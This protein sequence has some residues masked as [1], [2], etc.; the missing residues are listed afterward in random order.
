VL[1]DFV[2]DLAGQA[3]RRR[4]SGPRTLVVAEA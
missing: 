2:R 4:S 1:C 3:I